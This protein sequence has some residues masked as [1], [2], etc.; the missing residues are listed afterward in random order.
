MGLSAEL[1]FTEEYRRGFEDAMAGAIIAAGQFVGRCNDGAAQ[2][3]IECIEKMT[4]ELHA[5]W[6]KRYQELN[7]RPYAREQYRG[8]IGGRR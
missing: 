5:E 6:K 2:G 7:G 3:A 8:V 1:D 4:P